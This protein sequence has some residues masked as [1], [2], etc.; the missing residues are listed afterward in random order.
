MRRPTRGA[1][2]TYSRSLEMPRSRTVQF[3]CSFLLSY[4]RLWNGL[5]ESVFAVK[6]SV[7][8]RLQSI[9][10]FY[11]V[12]CPLFFLFFDFS[13]IF[14]FPGTSDSMG[15]FGLIDSLPLLMLFLVFGSVLVGSHACLFSKWS[16][17]LETCHAVSISR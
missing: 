14:P 12:D 1:L 15:V 13:F 10:F 6:M 8:L 16:P 7:L 9:A 2:T 5:H 11:K 3:S 17:T 4:V